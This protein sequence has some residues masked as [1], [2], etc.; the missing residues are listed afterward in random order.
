M[1]RAVQFTRLPRMF[2]SSWVDNKRPKQR[3]QFN[4]GS[5]L[6]RDLENACIHFKAR[7]TLASDRNLWQAITQQ[8]NVHCNAGGCGYVWPGP[9]LCVQDKDPTLPA[10]SSYAGVL[11]GSLPSSQSKTFPTSPS[12]SPAKSTLSCPSPVPYPSLPSPPSL[13]PPYAALVRCSRHLA[14]KAELTGGR[15]VYS[16][17]DR[18]LT[19]HVFP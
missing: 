4:Y 16:R 11:I 15:R 2:L 6:S 7:N 12:R 19:P 9:E 14:A 18:R 8:K 10:P 5:W 1:R 17:G 13:S 3:P